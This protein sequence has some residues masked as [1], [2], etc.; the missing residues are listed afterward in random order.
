MTDT[1]EY[2][3]PLGFLGHIAHALQ[4]RGNVEKIF[5]YRYERVSEKF[6]S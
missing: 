3:L 2:A 6:G 4:V 1:L 5:D